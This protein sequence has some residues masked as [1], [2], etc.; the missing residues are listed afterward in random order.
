MRKLEHENLVK[1][2]GVAVQQRF[3]IRHAH[4]ACSTA[5]SRPLR[6]PSFA[7]V[8]TFNCRRRCRIASIT[9]SLLLCA[10]LQFAPMSPLLRVCC[11]ARVLQPLSPDF[12]ATFL[13]IFASAVCVPFFVAFLAAVFT[14]ASGLQPLAVHHRVRAV[15][16]SG[17]RAADVQREGV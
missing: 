7:N 3:V 13:L 2:V 12:G 9:I 10:I 14:G 11:F 17:R 6:H 16:R 1:L 8:P 15:R 4:P 5:L